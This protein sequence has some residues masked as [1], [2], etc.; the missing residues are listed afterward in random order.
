MNTSVTVKLSDA[1]KD[2]IAGFA[3]GGQGFYLYA[4]TYEGNDQ[5]SLGPHI[6]IVDGSTVNPVIPD[7]VKIPVPFN[8]DGGKL[9]FIIQSVT[10]GQASGLF[11]GPHAAIKSQ[12][13]LN[14][15]NAATHD[16]RYDSFEWTTLGRAG[17]SGNLTDVEVFGIPM[18]INI[19]Y[20][21][22]A[23]AAPQTRGYAVD[24]AN[25]FSQIN[26][27]NDGALVYDFT[28]GP[29]QGS[30]RFATGPANAVAPNG[31][32]GVSAGD[33]SPYVESL[34]KTGASGVHVAG[35]FNGAPSVEWMVYDGK[36]VQYSEYHN[37]GFYGFTATY[38]PQP[39]TLETAS[40]ST[41]AANPFQ[42]HSGQSV[43]TVTDPNAHLYVANSTVVTF[44]NAADV[45]G[46]PASAI[47]GP[48]T[49]TK[50]VD[51]SHY[52]ISISGQT[53]T[54]NTPGGGAG[55]TSTVPLNA[56]PFSA[57]DGDMFFTVTDP[58][59]AGYANEG[60]HVTFDGATAFAGFSADYLNGTTFTITKLIDATHYR[61]GTSTA[62]QTGTGGGGAVEPIY[63]RP[64]A[65]TF[66]FTPDANSQI[67]GTL[68]I[69]SQDLANSI[70]STLGNA[71]IEN[72][73][74][75]L[76]QFSG[77]DDL[78]HVVVGPAMNTGA[79]NEWGA[80]LTKLLVAFDAGYLGSTATPL[81]S[82]LGT[83]PINL[84]HTWN[85]DPTFA[86]GGK[87]ASGAGAVT[88]WTWDTATY[89]TGQTSDS[90][91]R[92]FFDH[93][94]SYGN[95]YSD[96]LTALFQQGGPLAA[97][98]YSATLAAND[99]FSFV[100]NSGVVTVTDP[101]AGS[102]RAG[103]LVSFAG[104][105]ILAGVN[106]NQ[107]FAITPV[108][109]TT[110]QVTL[111]GGA[112]ANAT[113]TGGGSA[114]VYQMDVPAV[115]FTD[116][117]A[118]DALSA[119]ESSGTITVTDP[120]AASYARVGAVVSFSGI[121]GFAGIDPAK[122][123][124]TFSITKVVD[125][126]H[127]EIQLHGATATA[128]TTGGG[129]AIVA[130]VPG[131]AI[132]LFDVNQ[133][134]YHGTT[135]AETQG[136]TPTR[137]YNTYDPSLGPLKAPLDST[138]ASNL[139]LIVGMGVGQVRVDP[140]AKVTLG[141]Y[142]TTTGGL[143][144]FNTL[145]IPTDQQITSN[146]GTNPFATTNESKVVTVTD[147]NA[148]QYAAEGASVTFSGASPVA[149]LTLNGTFQIT[150]VLGATTYQIEAGAT[151]NA[152]TTGGGTVSG[153]ADP[154]LYQTWIFNAGTQQF[155]PAGAGSPAGNILQING[156][157]YD[158]G[159]NWYQ[160]SIGND[161]TSRTYNM[162]MDAV[163]GSGILNPQFNGNPAGSIAFDNLAA[164]PAVLGPNQYL[165]SVNVGLFNGGT[166]SMDPAL[167]ELVTD[168]AIIGAVSNAS[169][170]PTPKA[171]VLG[172][173]SGTTFTNWTTGGSTPS[174]SYNTPN[175]GLGSVS[176]GDLAFGW[177]GADQQWVGYNAYNDGQPVGIEVIDGYTNKVSGSDV[178]VLTFSS[179]GPYT[180]HI[181]IFAP[182]DIDGKWVVSGNFG[183]GTYSATMMEY[184]ASDTGFTTPV[185]NPSAA[186]EFTVNAL[187]L[188]FANTGGGYLQLDG[189]G[190][191]GG[192]WIELTTTGSSMP[193]GTL[194]V[195]ATDMFGNMLD[196]DGNI[197]TDLS[198]A[199]L[200]SIGSVA[201]DNGT[202]MQ[203]GTQ[204]VYLPVGQQLHFAVQTGNNVIEQLPGVQVTGAGALNVSVSGGF[205]TLNLSATVDNTLSAEA[206]LAGSQR[207][208]NEA[209]VY[210]TQGQDVHV[211]VQGSA[212][213]YNTIHFVKIDVNPVNGNWSVG[214]VAY[215]NTDAFRASVVANWDPG[216]AVTGGR[217]NFGTA[218]DWDVSTGSG[219]YAPV[220]RTEG[221]DIFV[222][223]TANVDGQSHIR[224][225][226]QNTFGFEDLRADQNSDFDYNDLVMKLSL[227]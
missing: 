218:A 100:Q 148:G 204:S 171:P 11:D 52:E 96:G 3:N 49:V 220:L 91:A 99:P 212:W 33:W 34:G 169:T 123:N 106:M 203:A 20:P 2:T 30:P 125:A 185:A 48:H 68:K 61:V 44:S 134:A 140:D 67:Q 42:P 81:N 74:G 89:G 207:N 149:G 195:F 139:S 70:Y 16:F 46:F 92:I 147:P 78:G 150:K 6:T 193:N 173:L 77:L 172:T 226:G 21:A 146:L 213:N 141:F 158:T 183:N 186:L 73:D 142:A 130:E 41:L 87:I 10:A 162:Y 133:P 227:A 103:Q 160:L 175:S 132:T 202:V 28:A 4:I 24:G 76:Y 7:A 135:L 9:Y 136:Y 145:S 39:L 36:N 216:F 85:E 104:L 107:T 210:L 22:V 23:G 108:S 121:D 1:L 223:G 155:T 5:E 143:A 199:V 122:L 95:G 126:T 152:T 159:V 154:I 8:L 102:Y 190:G 180:S 219:F 27:I 14:W 144:T 208:H 40:L 221:G 113:T 182:A 29:L 54:S 174:Y 110:Y 117:L 153:M 15:G 82:Q 200:A 168:S 26:D 62:A 166:V 128:T 111:P 151:A 80:F 224:T 165:T 56:N 112:K 194:L 66:V 119:V 198:A 58:F 47:N 197:T 19:Q 124:T 43:I 211:D 59:A 53:A 214:G 86:F 17:D 164:L 38:E 222:I 156:L 179:T 60:V 37:P 192:S 93:T 189:T 181:P 184:L 75:S 35:Y 31:P 129:S 90:Y 178:A 170:W 45:G 94:N 83:G 217:G 97:T 127:Y 13:D 187:N 71:T 25:I 88:S 64:N 131:I 118:V 137:I 167:L 114:V 177:W 105:P 191:G 196:R 72:P 206:S 79:N 161:R 69:T 138:G 12:G 109:A 209:W 188:P 157:P 84:G 120:H 116:T 57:H 18:S 50:I 65:G 63:V 98:G 101:N 225:Y 115:A 215:G 55:V 51:S 201:F 176:T 205:G 32:G 163:A